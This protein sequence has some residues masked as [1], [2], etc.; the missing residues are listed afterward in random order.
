ME[1]TIRKVIGAAALTALMAS[2]NAASLSL[3]YSG[4]NDVSAGG[5]IQAQVGDALA[6]DLIMDF[7]GMQLI[8]GVMASEITIGGTFD[9]VFDTDGL[10]FDSYQSAGLGDPDFGRD[11]DVQDGLLFSGGFGS[12][13]GLTGPALVATITFIANGDAGIYRVTTF[14][15]SGI[16]NGFLSALDL[17]TW[18]EVDFNG[19]DVQIVPVPPAVWF[20]LS[21]LGAL[22]GFARKSA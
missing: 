16:A 11:P 15:N 6:F 17:F 14:G 18:L 5:V 13:A 20:L 4:D 21:G 22:V 8:G 19:A 3:V 10:I 9:I 1:I 12:F 7:S 2:A